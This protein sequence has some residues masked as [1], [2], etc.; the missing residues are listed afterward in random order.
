MSS[1]RELSFQSIDNKMRIYSLHLNKQFLDQKLFSF[2]EYHKYASASL[3]GYVIVE[4]KICHAMMQRESN[5]KYF[6][7]FV[8]IYVKEISVDDFY[9]HNTI[10]FSARKKLLQV[11]E[12][13]LLYQYLTNDKH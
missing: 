5:I 12:K 8:L 3:S 9:K 2:K 11:Y 7:T 1:Q 4:T 13:N 10:L 6:Q